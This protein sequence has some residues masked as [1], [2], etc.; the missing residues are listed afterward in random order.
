MKNIYFLTF[1]IIAAIFGQSCHNNGLIF[2]KNKYIND[3][4]DFISLTEEK[5]MTYDNDAWEKSQKDFEKFSQKDF[6]KFKTVLTE[7]EIVKIDK[8]KGRYYSCVAKQKAA[9]LKEL[10]KHIYNQ[11]EGFIEGM[12]K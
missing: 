5:Y 9:K 11:T 3:F 12:M 10:F 2:S 1:I 6:E 8:L 4:G 7:E